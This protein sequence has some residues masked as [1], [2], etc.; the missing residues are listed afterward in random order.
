MSQKTP[1][2]KSPCTN[3]KACKKSC[4]TTLYAYIIDHGSNDVDA[5][6]LMLLSVGLNSGTCYKKRDS[7]GVCCDYIV[8]LLFHCFVFMILLWNEFYI[9]ELFILCFYCNYL[10]L[11]GWI[12]YMVD[13]LEKIV[14]RWCYAVVVVSSI[15]PSVG[16]IEI[17]ELRKYIFTILDRKLYLWRWS[18]AWFVDWLERF[19]GVM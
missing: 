6:L 16:F 7:L 2:S 9:R 19:S 5:V 18:L 11:L 4:A 8:V 1:T 12:S 10:G 13:L 14:G 3:P 17:I 15:M